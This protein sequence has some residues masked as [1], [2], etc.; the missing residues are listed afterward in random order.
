MLGRAHTADLH[1]SKRSRRLKVVAFQ[2][3]RC[4][5]KFNASQQV[6]ALQIRELFQDLLDRISPGKVFQQSDHRVAEAANNRLT[7]ADIR[8]N[9]DTWKLGC[10]RKNSHKSEDSRRKS[11]SPWSSKR[12]P[13]CIALSKNGMRGWP[14]HFAAR[15]DDM[16][17]CRNSSIAAVSLRRPANSSRV[18]WTSRR[19]S[20]GQS[21]EMDAVMGEN[22]NAPSAW[23][24]CTERLRAGTGQM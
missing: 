22:Y 9:G 5:C 11:A 18:A 16:R 1:R 2:F 8:I 15:P 7:V 3:E 10:I 21:T 14:S 23:Q 12:A 13:C 24:A 19:I 4:G 17:P 6:I 20:S